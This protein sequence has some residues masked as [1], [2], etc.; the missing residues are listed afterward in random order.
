MVYFK[1]WTHL[2][3][4]FET[5]YC[6]TFAL[7]YFCANLY[8]HWNRSFYLTNSDSLIETTNVTCM[9]ADEVKA[10]LCTRHFQNNI[11]ITITI[12]D[13]DS[14]P[15]AK[16]IYVTPLGWLPVH[17]FAAQPLSD[18]KS[19]PCLGVYIYIVLHTTCSSRKLGNPCVRCDG[20]TNALSAHSQINF[21]TPEDGPCLELFTIERTKIR[22]RVA[23]HFMIT[24]YSHTLPN[25]WFINFLVRLYQGVA[26]CWVATGYFQSELRFRIINTP[27]IIKLHIRTRLKNETLTLRYPQPLR[28]ILP[29][30]SSSPQKQTPRID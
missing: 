9:Y 25:H 19:H 10:P 1:F 3:Y 13:F 14:L 16:G 20:V 29:Y 5:T 17:G 8:Y 30:A 22:D 7:S 24:Q 15:K 27:F 28:A 12:K 18:T 26:I 23:S 4:C 11:F 6:K 21:F 2:K